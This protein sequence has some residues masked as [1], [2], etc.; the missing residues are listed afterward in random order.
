LA[1]FLHN[2]NFTLS[3]IQKYLP[4]I[5]DNAESFK[6]KIKFFS[7]NLK[8]VKDMSLLVF[9]MEILFLLVPEKKAVTFGGTHFGNIENLN[10]FIWP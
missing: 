4:S 3:I 2:Q 10:I 5:L 8:R 9:R 6:V 1:S 7:A